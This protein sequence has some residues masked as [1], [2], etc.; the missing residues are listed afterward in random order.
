MINSTLCIG[1]VSVVCRTYIAVL[2]HHDQ[3]ELGEKIVYF[4][5]YLVVHHSWQKPGGRQESRGHGGCWLHGLLL[6]ACSA[7]SLL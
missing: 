5:F 7:A 6:L 1:K 4:I 2:K 3:K